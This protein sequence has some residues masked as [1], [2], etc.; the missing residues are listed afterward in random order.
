MTIIEINRN[1][2]YVQ[3]GIHSTDTNQTHVVQK[4]FHVEPAA[5]VAK[6]ILRNFA[7]T[8]HITISTLN[9]AFVCNHFNS[10]AHTHTHTHGPFWGTDMEAFVPARS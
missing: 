7:T 10:S 4:M 9:M 5:S 3:A 2:L 8:A 1:N 6:A